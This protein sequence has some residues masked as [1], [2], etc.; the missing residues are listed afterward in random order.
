MRPDG[1]PHAIAYEPAVRG[2]PR[3]LDSRTSRVHR[4]AEAACLPGPAL[5][6]MRILA[7]FEPPKFGSGGC[8]RQWPRSRTG[9]RPA[10]PPRGPI[11]YLRPSNEMADGRLFHMRASASLCGATTCR[12]RSSTPGRGYRAFSAPSGLSYARYCKRTSQNLP[13]TRLG[14]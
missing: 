1:S 5:H 11:R 8:G 14:E 6:R 9:A 12:D 10:R 2:V 7:S 3:A 13:S 4:L